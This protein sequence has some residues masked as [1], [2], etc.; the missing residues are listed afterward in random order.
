MKWGRRQWLYYSGPMLGLKLL[1]RLIHM[2]FSSCVPFVSP[3]TN[4]KSEDECS[5]QMKKYAIKG[6]YIRINNSLGGI[7]QTMAT[8]GGR[9]R[10]IASSKR[11]APVALHAL[12][13]SLRDKYARK[14]RK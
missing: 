6:D 8:P 13:M 10:V 14:G 7:G 9:R 12:L 3:L 11:L 2:C 1:Y 4:A 5:W